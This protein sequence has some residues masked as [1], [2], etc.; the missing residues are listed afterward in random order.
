MFQERE[1]KGL[2]QF[3]EPRLDPQKPDIKPWILKESSLRCSWAGQIK[4]CTPMHVM[5]CVFRKG[6]LRSLWFWLAIHT[7]TCQVTLV[8]LS[9]LLPT[10]QADLTPR[11]EFLELAA[12]RSLGSDDLGL[13]LRFRGWR[14]RVSKSPSFHGQI[15]DILQSGPLLIRRHLTHGAICGGAIQ[16]FSREGQGD[17][18]EKPMP[19]L[20]ALTEEQLKPWKGNNRDPCPSSAHRSGPP[21]PKGEVGSLWPTKV[22]ISYH[23]WAALR[24]I[25]SHGYE[26]G[27]PWHASGV[28]G[29]VKP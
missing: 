19:L 24:Q 26:R 25:C 29:G 8:L 27:N 6:T 12:G 22:G 10:F 28:R 23:L 21:D 4:H 1:Q 9:D 20:S 15:P 11:D 2:E 3:K 7:V 16:Q 17:G 13:V 18:A 5:W 14:L